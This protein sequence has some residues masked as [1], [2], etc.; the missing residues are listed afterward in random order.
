MA[1]KINKY[2]AIYKRLQTEIVDYKRVS[3]YAL[4]PNLYVYICVFT[5]VY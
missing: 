1:V 3:I 4:H 2:I 5:D